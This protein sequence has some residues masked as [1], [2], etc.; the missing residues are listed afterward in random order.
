M[1]AQV[2]SLSGEF[3]ELNTKV[4]DL[5]KLLLNTH[6]PKSARTEILHRQITPKTPPY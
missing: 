6:T 3:K 1:K 2:T 5:T 4:K